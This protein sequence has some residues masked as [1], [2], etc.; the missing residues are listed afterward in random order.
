MVNFIPRPVAKVFEQIPR[1]R[2]Q[3]GWVTLLRAKGS[4]PLVCRRLERVKTSI[5]CMDKC[6][7]A[8][9]EA[10]MSDERRVERLGD[11]IVMALSEDSQLIA[12]L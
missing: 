12:L 8:G 9:P 4:R 5:D 7:Q 3:V 6:S 10:P 2:N 1:E 11:R